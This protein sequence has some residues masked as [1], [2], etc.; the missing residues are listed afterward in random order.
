MHICDIIH[1]IPGVLSQSSPEYCRKIF[2]KKGLTNE[3]ICAIIR[4]ISCE[5]DTQRIAN[6]LQRA[7]GWCEPVT[8]NAMYPF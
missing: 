3:K 2:L 5:E 8:S 6:V 1:I 7:G 4:N